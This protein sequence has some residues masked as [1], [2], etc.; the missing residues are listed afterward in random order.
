MTRAGSAT[1]IFPLGHRRLSIIDL[2]TGHQPIHN[3]DETLWIVYNGEVYNFRELRQELEAL[4][5]RFYTRTDT[6]VLLH[7]Y[8]QYGEIASSA[9]TACSRWRFS[10][11]PPA[12]FSWPVTISASSRFITT[13]METRPAT[14]PA[15]WVATAPAPVPS[16]CLGDQGAAGMA[17]PR[18]RPRRRDRLR[19][20]AVRLAR[21]SPETF[22]RGIRKLP[23]AHYMVVDESGVRTERYWDIENPDRPVTSAALLPRQAREFGD[24]LEDSVRRRLISDVPVGSCLSGGLDS[25]AIV[26]IM[27]RLLKKA[28]PNQWRSGNRLKTFSAV[29]PGE[30][31][32]ESE[33]IDLVLQETAAEELHLPGTRRV[34][35]RTGEVCL[36]PGRAL[37]S[38]GPLPNGASCAMLPAK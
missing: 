9:L 12:N 17:R 24:L 30:H 1:A 35:R 19:V 11:G 34:L 5:H 21:A 38:T 33:Y 16:F 4:G 32:D 31:L 2:E 29:Y 23:T 18:T 13:M 6:E 7:A 27:D 22:F 14:A 26:C 15:T 28:F 3:E 36:P 37:V 10:T 20:P 25:S 8:E